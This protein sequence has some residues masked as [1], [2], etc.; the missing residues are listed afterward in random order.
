M[1]RADLDGAG[2]ERAFRPGEPVAPGHYEIRVQT[3]DSYY[4]KSIGAE[5]DQDGWWGIEIGPAPRIAITLSNRPASVSGEVS[6]GG[7]PV[8]GAPVYLE[9]FD[10]EQPERRLRL[11]E[12]RADAHGAYRFA[13][14]APGRYRLAGSFDFDPDERAGFENAPAF[15][16]SEGDRARQAIELTIP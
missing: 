9:R 10:P 15:T 6:S 16:L 13:G 3:N 4:V 1:R 8:P 11:I 5:A 12:T 2:P 14:L 7:S